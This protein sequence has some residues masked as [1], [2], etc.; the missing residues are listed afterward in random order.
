MSGKTM[1]GKFAAVVIGAALSF[2]PLMMGHH[3]MTGY[4]R[5]KQITTEGVVKEFGWNNPHCWIELEVV[6]DGKTEIWN[7]EMTAPGYLQKAGW[8]RTTV[9]AG[10]KVTIISNPDKLGRNAGLFVSVTL[11]DG[12]K[13]TERAPAAGKGGLTPAAKGK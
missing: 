5:T 10:D 9:K 13:M 12:S 11:A 2:A 7:F 8:K 1:S 3:A 6:K 4:D